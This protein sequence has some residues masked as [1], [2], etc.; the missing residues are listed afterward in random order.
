MNKMEQ[1]SAPFG[2][3]KHQLKQKLG[4]DLD[5][6]KEINLH[7]WNFYRNPG[8]KLSCDSSGEEE[9]STSSSE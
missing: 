9:D 1:K 5:W 8:S 3:T 4:G 2:F 7:T 6:F